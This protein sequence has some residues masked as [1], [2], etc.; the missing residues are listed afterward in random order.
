MYVLEDISKP[1]KEEQKA[2]MLSY[3]ALVSTLNDIK[4][5]NPFLGVVYSY[6]VL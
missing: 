2:A 5:D 4:D 3:D 1:S 6:T